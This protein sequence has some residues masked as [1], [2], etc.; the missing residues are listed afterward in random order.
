MQVMGNVNSL[1]GT[2]KATVGDAIGIAS[3]SQSGNEQRAAG[4]AEYKAAQVQGYAEG[5]A[6]RLGGKIDRVVGAV[7][8]DK[9]K[10]AS[11]AAQEEKGKAQQAV[12][13]S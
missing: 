5:T 11:G 2:A 6:D 10:E 7:T 1:A 9:E 3:L 13:L 8:G 12:N 4:N